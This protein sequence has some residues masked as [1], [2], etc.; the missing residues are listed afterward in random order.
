MKPAQH[1]PGLLRGFPFI[2]TLFG[3]MALLT[4]PN[5]AFAQPFTE[6][7]PGLPASAQLCVVWGIMT[8]TAISMCW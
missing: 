1:S 4:S 2:G 6:I 8:G 5:P 7:F 3:T